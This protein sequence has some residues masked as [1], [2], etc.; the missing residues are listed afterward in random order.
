MQ[1]ASRSASSGRSGRKRMHRR[2]SYTLKIEQPKGEDERHDLRRSRGALP[3][4][5]G[6]EEDALPR[7]AAPGSDEG[8]LRRGH[9]SRGGNGVEDQRMEGGEARGDLHAD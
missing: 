8:V 5:E 1:K 2:R 3:E 9:S 6:Q 7:Q 4:G